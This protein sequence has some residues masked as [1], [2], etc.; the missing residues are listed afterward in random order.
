M[1]LLQ[2]EA[3]G[4]FS[5]EAFVQFGSLVVCQAVRRSLPLGVLII[6]LDDCPALAEDGTRQIEQAALMVLVGILQRTIRSGDFIGRRGPRSFAVLV[7]D[8]DKAGSLR[9]GERVR[10]AL[11]DRLTVMGAPTPFRISIGIATMP[12]A[13]T[14]FEELWRSAEDALA[15]AV[16][17]GGNM[18][19]LSGAAGGSLAGRP[20]VGQT[21]DVPE[22]PSAFDL[23]DITV[24]RRRGLAEAKAAIERGEADGVALRASAGACTICM[25]AAG[26]TYHLGMLPTLPLIGCTSAGGCRCVYVLPSRDPRRQPLPVDPGLYQ[27][28]EIPRRLHDAARFGGHGRGGCKPEDLAEYLD[29]FPLL[30]FDADIELQANEVAFLKREARRA[31]ELPGSQT[32]AERGAS[33]PLDAPLRSAVQSLSKLPSAPGL[34]PP[35]K[36]NLY[37]TNWRILFRSGRDTDSVLLVDV[38]RIECFRDAVACTVGNRPERTIFFVK[39]SVQVAL[40]LAQ[41]VR[42]MAL[43]PV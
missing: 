18:D 23:A 38:S 42:A 15:Q 7:Q 40:V 26:D 8:A 5:R 43:S 21:A 27:H 28:L 31:R 25:D 29:T 41:A 33:I 35:S 24:R 12:E 30:P 16:N 20:T 17:R 4:V 19:W 14:A 37:I 11:P 6:S 9:F 13:G 2:D 36:G 34:N 32:L 3:S 10:A 39:D 1:E 22:A